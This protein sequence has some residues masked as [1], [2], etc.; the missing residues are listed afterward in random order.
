[1][2]LQEQVNL[3]GQV[4]LLEQVN[5]MEQSHD[6]PAGEPASNP[7]GAPDPAEVA[8]GRTYWSL[9]PNTVEL[10]LYSQNSVEENIV[11]VN[12]VDSII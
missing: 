5:L 12:I 2:S 9:E 8:H 6:E 1:M 3:L 10:I 11:D 7:V 4:S